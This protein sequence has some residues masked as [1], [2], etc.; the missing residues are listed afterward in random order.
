MR[1]IEKTKRESRAVP[2][3][4]KRI[5]YMRLFEY[6][7]RY[8]LLL[9]AAGAVLQCL[10]TVY[11]LT[12]PM[13]AVVRML[14]LIGT[15]VF[16][17]SV[18]PKRGLWIV[19]LALLFCGFVIKRAEPIV[20]GF[21]LLLEQAVQAMDL[22]LPDLMQR[23]LSMM[24]PVTQQ[25]D[26]LLAVGSLFSVLL[27][28]LAAC[29]VAGTYALGVVLVA[30]TLLLPGIAAGRIPPMPA[31][32]V[33]VAVCLMLA[34]YRRASETV[35]RFVPEDDPTDDAALIAQAGERGQRVAWISA[36]VAMLPAA[37]L[38][39]LLATCILPERDY[40][41]PAY[42]DRLREAILEL[43]VAS[44]LDGANDGL[45]H[46]DLTSLADIHFT[47]ETAIA[48]RVSD[49][50]QLYLAGYTAARFTGTHWENPDPSAYRAAAQRFNSPLPQNLHAS[51]SKETPY[52]I[53]VKH[54]DAESGTMYLPNGLLTAADSI[55]GASV[56]Q[57]GALSSTAEAAA[58]GYTADALP[59]TIVP[60][61]IPAT[62]DLKESYLAAAAQA[63]G[64]KNATVQQ[65]AAAYTDYVLSTYTQLPDEVRLAAEKLSAQYGLSLE[66]EDGG[67]DLTALCR[68]LR[69]VLRT[70]CS[71]VY[72]PQPMPEGAD[73]AT[74]FLQESREGYCVH[75][76]T[77]A[78]VLLRS[79]GIP[80]RY[81]EGYIV[82][83]SDYDKPKDREGYVAIEDT[84]AHAWAEVFDP[85]QLVWVPV[86]MTPSASDAAVPTATPAPTA[87]EVQEG[88][89]TPLPTDASTETPQP[90]SPA[91]TEAERAAETPAPAQTDAAESPAE[92]PTGTPIEGLQ[93]TESD[94][95]SAS[96]QE[97]SMGILLYPA[98][99]VLLVG[100]AAAWYGIRKKRA[101]ERMESSDPNTAVLYICTKMQKLL[102]LLSQPARGMGQ[103]CEDYAASLKRELPWLP[104]ASLA[105]LMQLGERAMFSA[106]R[107]SA[108]D[109]EEALRLYESIRNA[110]EASLPKGKRLLLR[111]R[112][113]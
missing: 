18:L 81:A 20:H 82:I 33:L 9:A 51:I 52:T 88:E 61:V 7:L 4:E 24:D 68:A 87:G 83:R 113:M 56:R 47:G 64:E 112:L 79:L 62:G 77:T 97:K 31:V 90:A 28:L 34:A 27:P 85:V 37:M 10:N 101:R 86:E 59:Y 35:L 91:P 74:W 41:R 66:A 32:S 67:Y 49:V 99:A 42:A 50:R 104:E 16:F 54:V 69:D 73:F 72:T 92:D 58:Q 45:S 13:D 2:S 15:A 57:D 95:V 102:F 94:G 98:L 71:Y 23:V 14:L 76:A 80:T 60:H 53:S 21:L 93:P 111:L 108:R 36:A 48:V 70:E 96:Q 46:G 103:S 110:A 63:V 100:G 78:A 109:R 22:V 8:A 107:C 105:A 40:V 25:R 44:L 19:L 26:I 6:L 65:S 43:D 38:T 89:E 29:I 17:A 106:E 39:L 30:A 1:R 12:L 11:D 3:I 55:A 84:H 5:P 75:F